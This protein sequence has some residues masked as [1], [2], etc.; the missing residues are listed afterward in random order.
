MKGKMVGT[1]IIL[2]GFMLVL[3]GCDSGEICNMICGF[4][5]DFLEV[6]CTQICGMVP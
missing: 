5:P 6:D 4:I 2:L 3:Q 1:L